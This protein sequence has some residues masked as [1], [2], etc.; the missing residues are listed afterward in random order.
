MKKE[1]VEKCYFLKK[2]KNRTQGTFT[3][4]VGSFGPAADDDVYL[5]EAGDIAPGAFVLVSFDY[6][7]APDASGFLAINY[8]GATENYRYSPIA[9][10]RQVTTDPFTLS[11]AVE[12][13]V[14]LD[15]EVRR[16]H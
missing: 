5:V 13:L 7:L 2:N 15:V 14:A 9:R 1:I 16:F 11:I 8:E 3:D 12:R 6:Q 10:K 4:L